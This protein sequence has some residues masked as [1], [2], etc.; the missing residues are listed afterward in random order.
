MRILIVSRTPWSE[1]NSFGNTFS[2][3][4]GGMEDV[5]IYNICCQDG[6]INNNIVYSTF[7]MDDISVL[8][9]IFGYTPGKNIINAPKYHCKDQ[10][11]RSPNILPHRRL[12]LFFIIR[13]LI[14]KFGRWKKNSALNEF[15]KLANPDIIYL[16]LYASWYMCDVDKYIINNCKAPV[17]G[18]ISDDIYSYP[19]L[20]SGSPLFQFYRFILRIKLRQLFKLV[21]YCEVF[22]QNMKCEYE[23]L[24]NIPFYVIGKGIDENMPD[25]TY[26][27][28]RKKQ[29]CIKFVYTGNIGGGRYKVLAD[30]AHAIDLSFQEGDA[31]LE[32][33]SQTHIDK[34][35]KKA[36]SS[37]HSLYFKGSISKN[38]ISKVQ[39]D[40]DFLV[41]VEG[42][43]KKSIFETRMSFSTKIIDYIMMRKPIFA[44]GPLSVNSISYLNDNKLAL[45]ASDKHEIQSALSK[46]QIGKIDTIDLVNSSLD[47]IKRERNLKKIQ[48]EMHSRMTSLL[49][50]K[51]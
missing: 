4:F 51:K 18:H 19:P 20:L 21:S 48:G 46:I 28:V 26:E 47:F 27:S 38:E 31:I 30:L 45:V 6:N 50:N 11:T 32:I 49:E 41:H 34:K 3:L 5:I 40:S 1:E 24:F 35:I 8:K 43:D 16:P 7:Q 10:T 17:V 44:I 12:T 39:M 2:N 37:C 33:Y 15:I 29:D 9:S 42:F 25:N 13:D 22:A 23:R 36:F 14:W